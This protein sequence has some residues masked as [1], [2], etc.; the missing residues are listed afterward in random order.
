MLHQHTNKVRAKSRL[1]AEQCDFYPREFRGRSATV[2]HMIS[3][4]ACDGRRTCFVPGRRRL[5][6]A[7]HETAEVS[8]GL[9]IPVSGGDCSHLCADW[10]SDAISS[11]PPDCDDA[12]PQTSRHAIV[13]PFQSERGSCCTPGE[14]TEGTTVMMQTVGVP[15]SGRTSWS[16][17]KDALREIGRV[18]AVLRQSRSSPPGSSRIVTP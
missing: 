3:P 2:G 4:L 1:V 9:R 13:S 15:S 11:S 16:A 6:E 8:R 5:Q 10:D 12:T 7:G 17:P 14:H 18:G